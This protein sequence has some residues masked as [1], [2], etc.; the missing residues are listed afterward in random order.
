MR[1][2]NHSAIAR[3]RIPTT[4]AAPTASAPVGFTAPAV[5]AFDPV[6]LELPPAADAPDDEEPVVLVID[7]LPL[8][9]ELVPFP[10]ALAVTLS[11]PAATD[12][13]PANPVYVCR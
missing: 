7:P 5:V 2:S 1:H 6:A 9:I 10:V 3:P 8:V 11:I 12:A 4:P 13:T